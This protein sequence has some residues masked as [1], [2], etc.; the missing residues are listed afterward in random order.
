M[1]FELEGMTDVC[2]YPKYNRLEITISNTGKNKV[3][4]MEQLITTFG[5]ELIFEALCENGL[6]K[7]KTELDEKLKELQ[8]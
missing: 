5:N 4:L 2:I 3:F 6:K 7:L 1:T 8:E